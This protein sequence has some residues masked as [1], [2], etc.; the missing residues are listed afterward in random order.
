VES[1]GGLGGHGDA[2]FAGG[3][4]VGDDVGE[5]TQATEDGEVLANVHLCGEVT[6]ITARY[7]LME[8]EGKWVLAFMN[9][10]VM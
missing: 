2:F 5:G 3:W 1:G 10:D 9:F 6:D 4:V 8:H 7:Y